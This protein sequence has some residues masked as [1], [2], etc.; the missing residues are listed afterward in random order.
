MSTYRIVRA[1]ESRSFPT[2]HPFI[3]R[4]DGQGAS[5]VFIG[6]DAGTAFAAAGELGACPFVAIELG[7][8]C[9]G[10]HTGEARGEE[11]SNVVGFARFRLGRAD[12]TALVE[13]RSPAEHASS[14][15]RGGP[16]RLRGGGAEGRRLRRFPRP[17]RGSA[18][19]T[20]PQR[21]SAQARREAGKRGGPGQD[22]L[23]WLGLPRRPDLAARTHGSGGTP[24]RHPRAVPRARPG[25]LCAGAA[26]PSC[27]ATGRSL[28]SP[29]SCAAMGPPSL[30]SKL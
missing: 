5:R 21:G 9:L 20:V 26:S 11:G 18:D 27:E 2:P 23:S 4:A 1:G 7:H 25:G 28:N 14:C 16:R 3:E 6:K 13:I 15:D 24:R 30:H 22:A 29:R 17:H 12:P 8:E 19:P 10:V